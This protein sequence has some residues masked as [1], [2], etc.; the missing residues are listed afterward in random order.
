MVNVHRGP[1]HAPSSIVTPSGMKHMAPIRTPS[2]IFTFGPISVKAPIE[3]LRPILAVG[4]TLLGDHAFDP[5]NVIINFFFNRLNHRL[6]I[7]LHPL[8]R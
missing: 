5:F 4:Y 1:I 2:P 6:N 3:T 7:D 8:W